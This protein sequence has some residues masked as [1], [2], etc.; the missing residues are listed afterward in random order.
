LN[1]SLVGNSDPIA[2]SLAPR[3]KVLLFP[4]RSPLNVNGINPRLKKVNDNPKGPKGKFA[5]MFT[6]INETR[7]K[8]LAPG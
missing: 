2:A 1:K 5:L 3:G 4:L 6:T 7:V 8:E